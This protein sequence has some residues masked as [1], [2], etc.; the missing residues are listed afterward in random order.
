MK[1]SQKCERPN[2]IRG[3]EKYTITNPKIQ[4][5]YP[6]SINLQNWNSLLPRLAHFQSCSTGQNNIIT[7]EVTKN[8]VSCQN[9]NLTCKNIA[10]SIVVV[11]NRKKTV[12]Q[13]FLT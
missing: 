12:L 3:N 10:V 7:S 13:E 9:F 5:R 2:K 1:Q 11:I 6:V 8:L 4:E